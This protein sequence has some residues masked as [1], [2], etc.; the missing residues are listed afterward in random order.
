MF[1]FGLKWAHVPLSGVN[2]DSDGSVLVG[3]DPDPPVY[4]KR[5]IG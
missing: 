5:T 3:T 2:R 1:Y 4:I